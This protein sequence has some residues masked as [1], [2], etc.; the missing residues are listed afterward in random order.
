MNQIELGIRELV[1]GFVE[2]GCPCPSKQS[3]IQRREGYIDSVVLAGPS[4]KMHEEFED[5]FDGIRIKIFKPTSEKL[6]PLTIYFHGGCFVSGGF[7]THEQQMRQL[8]KLS[9]TIVVCIRYRLAP[10]YHYPAAHDDVYKASIH[11]HDHGYE[12]GG[13][14][15]RISFVG[16]SAGAHLALVTSLRLKAKSNWLPRKQVLIYPMLD[17]QGKSDSYSQNGKDFI[18]TGGMLLSGFEMYLEGSN[19][20]NKH[21]EI[22]LLLRNDF[23]GLPPTY[24]VTAELDPLRDEGEEL[25]KKLLSSGVDAYCDRYLGVIHGF[26]QLSAVSK[27]AVRC[28][29][30]VARQIVN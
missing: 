5:E 23:S 28:I 21:P 14:P 11:I 26:F 16:D 18:I 19:V 15:K 20:S 25:Y 9:N 13:D 17:P 12:Y 6:L 29:E 22:S 27:S 1:E 24:I 8:A 7:A 2:A 30:N 3:V 10:E 4:P